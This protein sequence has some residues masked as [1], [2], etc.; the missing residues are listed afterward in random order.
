MWTCR[1]CFHVYDD[2][3]VLGLRCVRCLMCMGGGSRMIF[4]GVGGAVNFWLSRFHV[5][6]LLG[7]PVVRRIIGSRMN[8]GVRFGENFSPCPLDLA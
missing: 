5:R 1:G 4:R 3:R 8:S 6:G 7:V 2:W